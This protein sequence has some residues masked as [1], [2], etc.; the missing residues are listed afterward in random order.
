M[1]SVQPT[2]TL[3]EYYIVVSSITMLSVVLQCYTI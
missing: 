1:L 3:G 2:T